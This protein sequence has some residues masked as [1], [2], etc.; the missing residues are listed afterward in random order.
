MQ[1]DIVMKNKKYL[2]IVKSLADEL[3]IYFHWINEFNI[4]FPKEELQ[5]ELYNETAPN[6]FSNL[7]KFYFD[8]FFLKISIMLDPLKMGGFENLS[9]YQLEK[10]VSETSPEK[11]QEIKKD[12]DLIKDEAKVILKV[13]MKIIAH[14]DLN[15]TLNKE[16]LGETKF[17]EIESIITK[18]GN[19]INK[20]LELLGQPKYSFLWLRDFN[21]AT[22][23]IQSLKQSSYYHD[24]SI[25]PELFDKIEQTE[26]KSKYYKL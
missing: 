21:G 26:I 23:L 15:V 17:N 9:L 7:S 3:S 16:H 2:K 11:K 10:I 18:M 4:L 13:R 24:L 25:E 6:F 20:V 19:L 5:Y 14:K 12:I 22:S 1:K 8:H